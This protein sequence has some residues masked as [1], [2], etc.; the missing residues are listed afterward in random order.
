MPIRPE[1]YASNTGP[2]QNRPA[3]GYAHHDNVAA[4]QQDNEKPDHIMNFD[5]YLQQAL[6]NQELSIDPGW[7]Q[8]RTTFGGLSA[9]LLLAQVEQQASAE[10]ILRSLSI[11]FCGPLQT[12]VPFTLQSQPRRVGKSVAHYQAERSEEHTSE[13]QSRENLVCRLLLEKKKQERPIT[14]TITT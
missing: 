1:F 13:L 8:G 11:S 14:T 10:Q 3:A 5:D 6:H 4:D 2:W 12:D 9:A 7:G